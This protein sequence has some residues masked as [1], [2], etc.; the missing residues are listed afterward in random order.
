M[1]INTRCLQRFVFLWWYLFYRSSYS[2]AA[3]L[4][5]I[6]SRT[7]KIYAQAGYRMINDEYGH[8]KILLAPYIRPIRVRILITLDMQRGAQPLWTAEEYSTR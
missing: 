3:A 1:F 6:Q 2:T 4:P 5:Q 7:G 8:L